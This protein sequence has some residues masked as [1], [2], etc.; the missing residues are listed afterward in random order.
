VRFCLGGAVGV[1]AYYIT[2]YCLT[3]YLKVWYIVSAVIA[4]VVNYGLNFMIQKFWTF[5]DK[6]IATFR[7]QMALYFTMAIC[8]LIGNTTFLYLMVEFLHLWYM[9]AQVMLTVVFT[10]LSFIVSRRIFKTKK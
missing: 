10:T 5:N 9:L 6:D 1:I 4:F 8:L 2:L 3:E 7:K